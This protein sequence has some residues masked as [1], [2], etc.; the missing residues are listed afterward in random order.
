METLKRKNEELAALLDV[1]MILNSSFEL[2]KNLLNAMKTLSEHLDMQRGTITLFDRKTGE[3]RIAV[4]HGLTREQ[5]ARGKYRIGEGIVGRVVETGSPMVIP[6]LGKEP[7][8]LNRTKARIEKDN[9]SFLCIPITIKDEVLGVLSVDRIFDKMV[10]IDEDLRV[11]QI[12]ATLIGQAIKIHSAYETERQK[13]EELTKELKNRY[14]LPN[15]ISVSDKMQEV[16]KTCLKVAKSRANVLLRGESGTGK[17]L[18]AKAL[19]YE[20]DRSSMPFVALNCAALPETLLE[21]ELFGYEKGAFTG[22]VGAKPGRFELA[23]K[24]TIF[25]DEIGDIN[26]SIQA[27][28]LRVLQE[29]TFERLGGTK[30]IHVDV[31]VVAATN[32]N[33]E[34]MV[35][36]NK[37]RED[38]YWRLNVVPIFIPALRDRREDIPPLIEHFLKRFNKEY[39]KNITINPDALRYLIEYAWPGNVRELENTIERLVVLNESGAI[40]ADE[41]P[42]YIK[43]RISIKNHTSEGSLIAE[44]E[45]LEKERIIEALKKCNFN[46]S[47]A[48]RLLGIT[49]RQIGY[50]IKKY[51]ITS[52][53]S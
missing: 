34:E 26:P 53:S 5:I 33:L 9:V 10:S 19:H 23:N 40:K 47:R 27:K 45:R 28:L 38:L 39:E 17:E 24:G 49:Q 20:S 15:I 11:L 3:L 25:L 21:A 6:D 48:A 16:I 8:F 43:D 29:H 50:K 31:R 7:L 32:R 41:L 42:S 1:S 36:A 2:E 13:K 37:F 52:I 18:I 51:K 14:S 30:S 12:I 46:Q 35:K 22:A 44:K 4:A